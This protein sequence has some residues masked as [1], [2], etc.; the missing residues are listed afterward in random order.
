M[1]RKFAFAI[2]LILV[3]AS[4]CLVSFGC[5]K[6][7]SIVGKWQNSTNNNTATIIYN[8]DG[9]FEM[10]GWYGAATFGKYELSG[11]DVIQLIADISTNS[12]VSAQYTIS[13]DVMKVS[14]NGVNTTWTRI[15]K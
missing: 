10:I 13:G 2:G 14:Q 3:V 6:S 7:S 15:S 11:S 8:K 9:T 12:S 5:S 1:T 4:L